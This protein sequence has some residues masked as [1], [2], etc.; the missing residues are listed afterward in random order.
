MSIETYVFISWSLSIFVAL[1][2]FIY[3]IIY[4][5]NCKE[6]VE[7]S[8]YFLIICLTPFGSIIPTLALVIGICVLLINFP[9]LL[10]KK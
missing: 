7:N 8:F 4:N 3:T 6:S 9:N 5:R 10:I 2:G 1:C